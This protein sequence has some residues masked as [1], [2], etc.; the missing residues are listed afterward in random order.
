M[1]RDNNNPVDIASNKIGGSIK[2]LKE[3]LHPETLGTRELKIS[4]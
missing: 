3:G 4:L 2:G 1:Y